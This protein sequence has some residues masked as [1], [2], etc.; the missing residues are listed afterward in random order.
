MYKNA[1]DNILKR[2]KSEYGDK[3]IHEDG[4]NNIPQDIEPTTPLITRY[5]I[6]NSHNNLAG[7]VGVTNTFTSITLTIRD[8][9]M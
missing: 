6:A 9:F 2:L 1:P 8:H 7:S 5:A 4:D 3:P